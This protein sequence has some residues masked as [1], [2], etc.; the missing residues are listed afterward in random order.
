[1]PTK[2]RFIKLDD[3]TACCLSVSFTI[4]SIITK[5]DWILSTLGSFF[6]FVAGGRRSSLAANNIWGNIPELETS[7]L[8]FITKK[9]G[10]PT[11]TALIIGLHTARSKLFSEGNVHFFF[12]TDSD[13]FEYY[14]FH[15]AYFLVNP[16]MQKVN[17]NNNK[18]NHS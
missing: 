7:I 2:F 1:M 12:T 15:F 8:N 14:F 10:I 17:N 5:L 16:G 3:R 4:F 9:L 18:S 11:A 13:A 6:S